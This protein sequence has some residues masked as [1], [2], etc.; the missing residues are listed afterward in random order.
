MGTPSWSR[1]QTIQREPAQAQG[2][3]PIVWEHK[4]LIV[5]ANEREQIEAQL[6]KL[7][8]EG[9]ECVTLSFPGYAGGGG[10]YLVLKRQR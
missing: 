1:I 3:R 9:W 10:A 6:Q 5:A 4:V 8:S 7:G 2:R